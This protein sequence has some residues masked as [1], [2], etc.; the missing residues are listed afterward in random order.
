MMVVMMKNEKESLTCRYE[1]SV[2]IVREGKAGYKEGRHGERPFKST[3]KVPPICLRL[4]IYMLL[5]EIIINGLFYPLF[6]Y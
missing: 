5:K 6:G 2:A 1:V 4:L 3:R